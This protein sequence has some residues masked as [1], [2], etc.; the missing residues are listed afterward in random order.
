MTHQPSVMRLLCVTHVAPVPPRAGNAVRIQ[1]LLRWLVSD[2]WQVRVVVCPAVEPG[3][4]VLAAM[5]AE[6]YEVTVCPHGGHVPGLAARLGEEPPAD[7]AAARV[8]RLVSG[9]CPDGLVAQ[10]E[11]IDREWQPDVVVAEYAF[12]SRCFGV[13]RPQVVKVVDAHDVFSAKADKVER[14]GV[15]DGYALTAAEEA[16]LLT[17]ADVVVAIQAD[18]AMVLARLAPHA[19]VVSAGID[20]PCAAE[21]PAAN[22]AVSAATALVV[23][24]LNPMNVA[25][26]TEF[27]HFAWPLVRAAEPEATLCVVGPLG[28]VVPTEAVAAGVQV[29]GEVDDLAAYYRE[30]ALAVNP[31][32]AGTGLKVKTVEAVANGCPVVVW[33]AGADGVHPALLPGCHVA[34]DWTEL[35]AKVVEGLRGALAR[36]DAA[37]VSVAL[38]AP[39]VYGRLGT[40][41]RSL[42]EGRRVAPRRSRGRT[43]T[44]ASPRLLSLFVQHGALA[45]PSALTELRALI[46]RQL[47]GVR[48]DVLV[49]DNAMP[50]R[51]PH[52]LR[53][54]AR[55]STVRWPRAVA[56]SNEAW[57]FSAWDDGIAWMGGRLHRYDAVAL[58]TSAFLQYDARR[59]LERLRPAMVEMVCDQRVVLGHT[60]RY[61]EPVW[62]DGAALQEWVRSSFL[63]VAPDELLRLGSLV[64]AQA[65]HRVFVD[66]LAK[67]GEP[68][69][70]GAAVSPFRADAPLS[71]SYQ[72]YL[73]GWLTGDGTGQGVEWHSRFELRDAT[74]PRFRAKATAIV[75][76]QLLTYRLRAQGCRPVDLTAA[77]GLAGG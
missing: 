47:P 3:P 13:L 62:F 35:A 67:P 70:P 16:A 40:T 65:M 2:G 52:P 4:E 58:V 56:A 63:L 43:R 76:E 41:L 69:E 38:S 36:A 51:R 68:G 54:V 50:A 14:L 26:L 64:S 31:A 33:P 19:T 44:G 39:E 8:R 61:D 22:A 71:A 21:R 27:L 10:V 66:T 25:G 60:D 42:V 20:L 5:A 53:G 46:G 45:Y 24:S 11:V 77:A 55:L 9:L 30:A 74:L 17:P 23:G 73:L 49:L 72:R 7:A 57:E 18:E 48:H 34:S 15:S 29:L 28:Q 32:P 1:R 59:H 6:P 37:D 75:N 12:L